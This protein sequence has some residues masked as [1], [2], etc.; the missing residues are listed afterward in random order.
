VVGSS[1]SLTPTPSG[2]IPAGTTLTVPPTLAGSY[3][4]IVYEGSTVVSSAPIAVTVTPQGL[5]SAAS[6]LSPIYI[7]AGVIVILF[8]AVLGLRSYTRKRET[9]RQELEQELRGYV[10]GNRKISLQEL[11]TKL[12]L[13][14]PKTQK[15]I[16]RM[17]GTGKLDAKVESGYVISE[18]GRLGTVKVPVKE[19][20]ESVYEIKCSYCGAFNRADS[21]NCTSCGAQLDKQ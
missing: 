3:F 13:T 9:T 5:A 11:S 1:T 18:H 4:V 7:S 10:Q 20:T 8:G 14:V 21:Q 16:A 12:K 15:L 17:I 19:I 6:P 2:T